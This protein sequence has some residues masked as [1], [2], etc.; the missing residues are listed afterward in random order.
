MNNQNASAA[1]QAVYDAA[2]EYAGGVSFPDLA[3]TMNRF[4]IIMDL[5]VLP[6]DS[7]FAFAIRIGVK[8]NP[9]STVKMILSLAQDNR[10]LV[11]GIV[12]EILLIDIENAFKP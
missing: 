11:A 8:N 3:L 1:V 9:N 2:N 7:L 4:R 12:G 5:M 6:G 10:K